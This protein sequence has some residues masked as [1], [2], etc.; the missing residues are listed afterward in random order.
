MQN[1]LMEEMTLLNLGHGSISTIRA[2]KVPSHKF[3]L[4][5]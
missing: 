3:R 5:L 2:K 4:T 1:I